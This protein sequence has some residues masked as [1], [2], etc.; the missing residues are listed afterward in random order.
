MRIRL[1][2]RIVLAPACVFAIATLFASMVFCTSTTALAGENDAKKFRRISV[3]AYRDKMAAG[4]IGQM[5]G[6]GWGGPT[7]FRFN[8][9]IIPQDKVPQWKPRLI[10]QFEQDDIYV[11][12]TFLKTLDQYGLDVSIRQAGIDFGNSRYPL[13][14]ANLAG[15]ENIRQGIAPPDSGHPKFNGHADDIDYQIEADYAGLISPGMPNLGIELGEKFGRLMNYGDGVYGGQFVSGMYSE[16]FFETDVKKIVEAGLKCIPADSQFAEAIRDVL[17]WHAENPRDWQATWKKIDAKYQLNPAYRR[18]SC[19]SLKEKPFNIDAKINGAYIVMGLLYGEGDLDKTIVIS[20]RCGQDSDCNPSNAAGVL[21][22][23]LGRKKLPMRFTSALDPRPKFSH[24]S[25]NFPDLLAVCEKLARQAVLRAGGRIEREADDSATFV[26]LVEEPKPGKLEQCWNPGPTA[27]SVFTEAEKAMIPTTEQ[28]F[29]ARFEK[30]I[31]GW[32]ISDCGHHMSP[33]L[34]EN[35]RGKE[36]VFATHPADRNTACTIGRKISVPSDGKTELHLLVGHYPSGDWDLL[37]KVDGKI[38]LK[39]TI[40][41]KISKNTWVDV[42]VDLSPFAGKSVDLE[43]LNQANG[44]AS[45][46]AYWATIK[47]VEQ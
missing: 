14:H 44:W 34:K 47:V 42:R 39:K 30:F 24:T 6:V 7:E 35:W 10:N 23:S 1:P 45:E 3:A 38:L 43:L 40:G 31:A 41:A 46:A 33:G 29:Q 2:L 25:Y 13:W 28:L 4:W 37:V 8:G 18:F 12:M 21:A 27:D 16:A 22:T 20:M 15:R 36:R 17:A 26:I 32:K 9:R 11:E 19:T 5:A